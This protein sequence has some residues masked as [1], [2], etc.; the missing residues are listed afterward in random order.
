MQRFDDWSCLVLA[1]SP[2]ILIAHVSSL[3]FDFVQAANRLQRLFSQLAFVRHV[4]I[5]ELAAGVGHAANFGDVFL[6]TG[7]VASEIV[8]D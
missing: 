6:E 1:Y 8:A 7:F 2:A 5:E 3:T 4:Q